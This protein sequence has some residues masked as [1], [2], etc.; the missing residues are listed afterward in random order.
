MSIICLIWVLRNYELLCQ[1]YIYLIWW[2]CWFTSVFHFL[3]YIYHFSCLLF[4][5][6]LLCSITY[7]NKWV[8]RPCNIGKYWTMIIVFRKVINGRCFR[9]A[10]FSSGFFLS[11]QLQ[12]RNLSVILAHALRFWIWP[13]LKYHNSVSSRY[14]IRT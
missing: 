1:N 8:Q 13:G 14:L 9:S 5:D 2:I 6:P 10:D 4:V 11:S 12:Q 7:P 3:C